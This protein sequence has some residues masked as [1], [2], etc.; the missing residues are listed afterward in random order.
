MQKSKEATLRITMFKETK[1]PNVFTLEA[2]FCGPNFGPYAGSHHTAKQ[3]QEMGK[4]LC[5]ALAIYSDI[6]VLD[7][8]PCPDGEYANIG[9]LKKSDLLNELKNNKELL[10][11]NAEN[12]SSGSDSDPSEDNLEPDEFAEILPVSIR[13]KNIVEK[14]RPTTQKKRNISIRSFIQPNSKDKPEDVKE[15]EV[16]LI[17]CGN[18]NEMM[19]PGHVCPSP[20]Q[21]PKPKLNNISRLNNSLFSSFQPYYNAAGKKVRDQATQTPHY[22]KEDIRSSSNSQS[23]DVPKDKNRSISQKSAPKDYKRNEKSFHQSYMTSGFGEMSN[24]GKF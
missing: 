4:Q 9:G 23:L 8:Q 21:K 15:K 24:T 16:P 18:C 13:R 17:K 14:K 1:V 22:K 10:E 2:S 7:P 12:E 20:T 11:D 6:S 5:L 19:T 3:L